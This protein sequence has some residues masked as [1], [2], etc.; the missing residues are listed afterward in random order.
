M[1]HLALVALALGKIAFAADCFQDQQRKSDEPTGD[2]IANALTADNELENICATTWKTNDDQKLQIT[3]NHWLIFLSIE[4]TDNTKPPQYC[5]DAFNNII[6]QCI[7]NSDTWGGVWSFDG[8]S[9]NI[10]NSVYPE[11]GLAPT[12]DGGPSTNTASTTSAEPRITSSGTITLE[13][14]TV[15]ETGTFATTTSSIA[16]LTANSVTSTSV[17]GHP[18]ILPIW[19]VSPGI[20]IIVIP[21]AGV[22]AGGIVPPPPGYPPLTIDPNGEPQTVNSDDVSKTTPS[23]TTESSFS[24]SSSSCSACATCVGF[25]VLESDATEILD[26]DGD[27]DLPNIDGA[28]W[29]SL[30]SM[31]PSTTS[32]PPPPA[33]SSAASL[34]TQTASPIDK[35]GCQDASDNVK[36]DLQALAFPGSIRTPDGKDNDVQA[37]LYRLRQVV[38]DGSCAVAEGIDSKYVAIYHNGGECEVAIGLSSTTEIYFYRSIWP[39]NGP[40]YNTIWQECWDSTDNIIKKCVKNNAKNGWWNG[41]HVYQFYEGGLRPLNDPNAKHTAQTTIGSWLE[42]PTEGLN[43]GRDCCGMILNLDWCIT[44]CGGATCRRGSLSEQFALRPRA[45]QSVAQVG[46]C[47]IPYVLPDYPSSGTASSMQ[48]VVKWYDRN[49]MVNGNNNCDNP[50]ITLFGNSQSGSN[51]DTEHVYEKH[52]VKRFLYYLIGGEQAFDDNVNPAATPSPQALPITDCARLQAVFGELSNTPNSQFQ[53]ETVAAQ[54]GKAV[55]CSGTACPDTGRGRLH[56]FFLLRHEINGMKNRIISGYFTGIGADA[57]NNKL[58]S[59]NPA[60]KTAPQMQQQMINAAL[61]VQYLREEAVFD[62]FNEVNNRMKSILHALD[63]EPLGST[64]PPPNLHTFTGLPSSWESAYD[65]FMARL[66]QDTER[67]M[68]L[69]LFQCK[70]NYAKKIDDDNSLDAAQKTQEKNKVAAFAGRTNNPQNL[71]VGAVTGVYADYAMSWGPLYDT[72]RKGPSQL[73]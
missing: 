27:I 11:N 39:D 2:Q 30:E 37:L 57:N 72:I 18:T 51:Y 33:T 22:I 65:E 60:S 5:Q 68:A 50:V 20:G 47:A 63:N 73:E 40:D 52:L 34:P 41:D 56:E 35:P 21:V 17:D 10:W 59:C 23:S 44:N 6:S 64:N 53:Q 42:P 69:W 24:S 54:L 16:G 70:E 19:F 12:D 1:F 4:R 7:Q 25:E 62:S 26:N 61:V 28:L 8:E 3:Y 43:C 14:Q 9:Y 36:S 45:T 29:S 58:P 67:K 15:I 38:C 32:T 66:I 71:G 48:E 31:Y 46:G 13:P 55:S 49:D